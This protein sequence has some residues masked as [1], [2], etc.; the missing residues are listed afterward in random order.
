MDAKTFVAFIDDLKYENEIAP[1]F[2]ELGGDHL[3][4]QVWKSETADRAM[5]KVQD[6]LDGKFDYRTEKINEEEM[7]YKTRTDAEV[8]PS[9][10]AMIQN[11]A[12]PAESG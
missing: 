1:N 3:G 2:I 4:P 8:M 7:T 11:N 5:A 10:R 9:I 12:M 6:K